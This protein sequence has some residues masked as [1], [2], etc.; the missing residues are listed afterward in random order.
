MP[1]NTF[2]NADTNVKTS[3]LYLI[4]KEKIDESQTPIFMAISN[5]VGH[6]DAGKEDL[7]NLDLYQE[8]DENKAIINNQIG[9]TILEE[10]FDFIKN[11]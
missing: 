5:S 8:Q 6:T 9:K 10:Y 11:V 2:V 1:R 3:I 7:K 4:K